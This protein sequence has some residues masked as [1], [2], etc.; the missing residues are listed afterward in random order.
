MIRLDHFEHAI[1]EQ[2]ERYAV[3][4]AAD[5]N[6]ARKEAGRQ[7]LIDM[8]ADYSAGKKPALR[9]FRLWLARLFRLVP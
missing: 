8:A 7:R 5:A 4:E 9:G 6:R 1:D 3:Q 2:R